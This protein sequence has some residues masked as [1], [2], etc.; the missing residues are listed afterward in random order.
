MGWEAVEALKEDGL[1]VVR[2]SQ[3]NT[4]APKSVCSLDAQLRTRR[5][6][7]THSSCSNCRLAVRCK[8]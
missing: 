6:V 5:H 2:S 8:A 7:L 4:P 3:Q 1:P